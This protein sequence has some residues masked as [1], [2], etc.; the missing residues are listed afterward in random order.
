MSVHCCLTGPL[1]KN[2]SC[3]T[4]KR[5]ERYRNNFDDIT[6][7]SRL[8][9]TSRAENDDGTSQFTGTE[10]ELVVRTTFQNVDNNING[11]EQVFND[12]S[13]KITYKWLTSD[14]TTVT[15]K[16]LAISEQPL[17]RLK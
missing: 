10:P 9:E 8:D 3:Y 14:E 4:K 17:N 7:D 5:T 6:L 13:I 16:Q 12:I 2:N 15:L 1:E 11:P